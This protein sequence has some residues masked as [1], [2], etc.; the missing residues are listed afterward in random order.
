[1]LIYELI[2]PKRTYKWHKSHLR[3]ACI[4]IRYVLLASIVTITMR[5]LDDSANR[6]HY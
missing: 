2:K 4:R 5:S 3:H 1:M 6:T